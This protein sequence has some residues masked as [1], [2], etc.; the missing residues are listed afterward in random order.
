MSLNITVCFDFVCPF[1]YLGHEV[2]RQALEK[3]GLSAKIT[4]RPYELRRPPAEQLD[5]M[6]DEVRLPRYYNVLKPRAE[7]LGIPMQL[8][9]LSPHPYTTKVLEGFHYAE[10][11]GKGAEYVDTLFHLFYVEEQDISQRELLEKVVTG[12]EMDASEFFRALDDNRYA[13]QVVDEKAWA[14]EHGVTGIPSYFING[15]LYKASSVEEMVKILT[16]ISE[17]RGTLTETGE[18]PPAPS[19]GFSCG[20]HGCGPVPDSEPSFSCGEH[21]CGPVSGR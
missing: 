12:L 10:S 18:E 7:A 2:L 1:C 8:P 14:K 19:E 13:R 3:T 11:Q 15:E 21:G 5:P 9:F 4:Y 6:H 20:E 16:D 17:H